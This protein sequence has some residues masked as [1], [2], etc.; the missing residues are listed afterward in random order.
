MT[1]KCEISAKLAHLY[2]ATFVHRVRDSSL[3]IS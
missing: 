3:N 2:L 1:V